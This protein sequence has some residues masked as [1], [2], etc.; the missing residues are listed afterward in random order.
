MNS[1]VAYCAAPWTNPKTFQHW[2]CNVNEIANKVPSRVSYNAHTGAL[3]SWGFAC[4][5]EDQNSD[6]QEHFKL[7]LDPEYKDDYADLACEDAQR[8]FYDYLCRVHDHVARHFND[9]IP[10][11][12]EMTVGWVFSVP[13]TWRDA[14]FVHGLEH[15]IRSAGFGKDGHSHE[16]RI[17]LT[18]AEAAAISVASRYLETN[19]NILVCDAGGGTTDVNILKFL[20]ARGMPLRL[21]S[22]SKVEGRPIGSALIDIRIQQLLESSLRHVEHRLSKRPSEVA[23][24]MMAGRF[25]RFKCNFGAPGSNIPYLLLEVP[26]LAPGTNIPHADIVNSR[27]AITSQTLERVFNEQ[28]DRM[29]AFIDDQV[30]ALY[31]SKPSEQLKYLVLSG[32]LGSSPYVQARLRKHFHEG[33]GTTCP[34]AIGL[35]I[36]V[37]EEPQLSVVHGLVLERAQQIDL[38]INPITNRLA[39][40]S[41]GV[42][43]NTLYDPR[44]HRG[45]RP[46]KDSRDGKLWLVDQIEWLIREGEKLPAD[47]IEK[48][49][50]AKLDPIQLRQPWH[51]QFVMC[52]EP[53]SR[54]PTVAS[55]SAVKTLCIIEA[56]IH[57]TTRIV[58][59]GHWWNL[60][61][62]YELTQIDVKVIPGSADLRF[63]VWND[64]RRL[65]GDLDKVD[66]KWEMQLPTQ[67]GSLRSKNNGPWQMSTF[68]GE[69]RVL[70]PRS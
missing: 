18:E 50:R 43:I 47:G 49:F 48:K 58:K 25:E 57:N 56:D 27:I 33:Q 68:F 61:R 15:L 3:T 41:Y 69:Q 37:A 67:T 39:R 5:V 28:V 45:Q 26:D 66:V 16:C 46:V 30:N 63:E 65:N 23:E 31:R 59:N 70:G 29:V 32:G 53:S 12:T 20:S 36:L 14:G 60:A 2:S 51:A 35:K 19:D 4:D 38:G 64:G 22:L 44:K 1:G 52:M 9:R 11:W 8:Y 21:E 10:Q 6:I 55:H 17:T 62:R 42:I 24:Q 7:Y 13:T 34:T 40:V 54:L